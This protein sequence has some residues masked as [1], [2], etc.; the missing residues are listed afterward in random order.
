MEIWIDA[1]GCPV[2]DI[3]IE[4]ANYYGLKVHIVCDFAHEYHYDG[5]DIIHCDTG[6]DHSDYVLLS[7][8]KS[9]DIMVTQD[10][11]L[12]A[13]ALGKHCLVIDQNGMRYDDD[14]ID[15]LL[16]RRYEA[17]KQRKHKIY[18]NHRKRVNEDDEA[19]MEGFRRLI[20][21]ALDNRK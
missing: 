20:E 17:G 5:V 3:V 1:D 13:M 16:H 12:A 9:G 11:G 7:K 15:T 10:Y 2:V 4:E 21:Q 19:F 8:I 18:V 6:A 14:N